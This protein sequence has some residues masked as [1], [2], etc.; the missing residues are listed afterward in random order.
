[1]QNYFLIN[2]SKVRTNLFVFLLFGLTISC[3]GQDCTKLNSDFAT[4]ES[5][6]K[7]IK[8]TE[9]R[10]LDNCDTS[11]SSWIS[12]VEFRSCDKQYGFFILSTKKK[13][14]IHTKVPIELWNE[15]KKAESFGK[16]YNSR[17]KGK[18][19]LII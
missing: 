4:Y 11:K 10:L 8:S 18:Y 17:I 6:M 3:Q 9:F 7:E 1:M 13:T 15:F 5:A 14:Y 2:T 19:Q 16:F 12:G